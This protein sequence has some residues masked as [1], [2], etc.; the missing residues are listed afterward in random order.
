MGI[1]VYPYCSMLNL[2]T[3]HLCYDETPRECNEINI[4]LRKTNYKKRQR[5]CLN[6]SYQTGSFFISITSLFSFIRSSPHF[7]LTTKIIDGEKVRFKTVAITLQDIS[8]I[9][10]VD[11]TFLSSY[12]F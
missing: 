6:F 12:I 4:I 3:I 11:L 10:P 2:R 1:M 7:P 9:K 8:K 5:A